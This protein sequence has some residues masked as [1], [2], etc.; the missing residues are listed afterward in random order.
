MIARAAAV[1]AVAAVAAAGPAQATVSVGVP[2][3]SD[4][5]LLVT[6]DGADDA[7]DLRV[8]RQTSPVVHVVESTQPIVR[9]GSFC[10]PPTTTSSGRFSIRCRA[11][12][13]TAIQ[14]S[15]G[16]GDDRWSDARVNEPFLPRD[17]MTVSGGPGNDRIN[18]SN[19]A[20]ETFSGDDGDDILSGGA[21]N[22]TLGG[23][24]G[25][26]QLNDEDTGDSAFASP[27][28]LTGGAGQD[29]L[30]IHE[31]F[32]QARGDAGGD[33]VV[34]FQRL[35]DDQF[36]SSDILDGGS[37]NDILSLVRDRGMSF[38]DEGSRAT[39]FSDS[40]EEERVSGFEGYRGTRAPDV[41]N[42]VGNLTTNS[43]YDGRGGPDVIVGSD[44]ADVAFGGDGSDR[45]S[46]RAGN[47]VVDA[48]DGEPVA[49]PDALVDC[50][51]SSGDQ[52]LIDLLDPEPVGCETFARSAIREGPHL[53][54]GTVRRARRG[55]WAVRVRCP[56]ALGHPCRGALKLGSTRRNAAR[57]R[58]ARYR[59]RHGRRATLRVRLRGRARR[60]AFVRSVER[61]DITGRKITLGLRLLRRR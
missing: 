35:E 30:T 56:R 27:D 11:E 4:L 49:V 16:G 44:H 2:S 61:G 40:I 7:I 23:G 3:P 17:P 47:D 22:D 50:G 24:N 21:G 53:V 10:D 33:E 13:P 9:A 5:R 36:P 43:F 29:K 58:G 51:S 60:R 15:L 37:E 18:G 45:I 26:D 14:A 34:S 54:I 38:R 57:G 46:T 48:K 31:G 39:L 25:N 8:D 19:V 6:A 32:D 20:R 42:A 55:A 52:A 1:A 41:F 28:E 59:V 12:D